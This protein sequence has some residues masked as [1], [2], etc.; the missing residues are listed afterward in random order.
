MNGSGQNSSAST[1]PTAIHWEQL[2]PRAQAIARTV[3]TSA[4]QGWTPRE[5]GR[6]F[7]I[8]SYSVSEM[9]GQLHDELMQQQRLS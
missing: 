5:I 3:A 8:S 2:S 6:G 1:V 7:G 9:M 4:S